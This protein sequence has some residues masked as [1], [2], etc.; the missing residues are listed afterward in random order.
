MATVITYSPA[1]TLV[2]TY[3]CFNACT[4]C[5]FRVAPG[6]GSW[7][8]LDQA[9][10]RLAHLRRHHSDVTEILLLSGEVHP[11]SP[12]RAQWVEHLY[13]LAKLAWDWGFWPHTNCGPLSEPEMRRLQTVNVSMGLM[14]EQLRADL[15]VHRQAPS[16]D[17]ALRLAQLEQAG[18]LGIPF[19]TGLL[20]GIGETPSDW[21]MTLQAIADSHR[22]WGHIQEVILQP[23]RQ[24]TRQMTALPDFPLTQMPAVVALAREILPDDITLQVPPNLITHPNVLLDCLAAGARD[25]GGIG[26]QDEVN[27]D[28]P[29]PSLATLTD[30][31]SRHGYCLQPRLP[32]YPKWLHSARIWPRS[33]PAAVPNPPNLV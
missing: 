20:L 11:R 33:Q 9:R 14:L 23:Y 3:E 13:Q 25:L 8:S 31:L 26:P 2:P 21:A 12:R 22:R 18:R 5:N 15:A 4:Y 17:P 30:L 16:K 19:T 28:Y 27:P 24:G 7:L 6:T 32:I 1:V 29:Y 10:H